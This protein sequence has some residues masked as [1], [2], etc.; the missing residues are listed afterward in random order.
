MFKIASL[1]SLCLIQFQ[2]LATGEKSYINP[3]MI[4]Y[5]KQGCQSGENTLKISLAS[6]RFLCVAMSAPEVIE[7]IRRACAK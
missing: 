4:V 3:A 2:N 5:I 6:D 1:A 7:Y